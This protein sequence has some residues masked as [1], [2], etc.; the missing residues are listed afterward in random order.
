MTKQDQS[1]VIQQF[2]LNM[3]SLSMLL[4]ISLTITSF[5]VSHEATSTCFQKSL[6]K[7]KKLVSLHGYGLVYL[8]M[9]LSSLHLANQETRTLPHH[10]PHL[11]TYYTYSYFKPFEPNTKFM[12]IYKNKSSCCLK[13]QQCKFNIGSF[14]CVSP[15]HH[16]NQEATNQTSVPFSV[17]T[18]IP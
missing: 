5:L 16:S 9:L 6:F 15:Q 1:L 11:K 10:V 13:S 4:V 3:T 8:Y 12:T 7:V 2:E 17:H 14:L 18:T